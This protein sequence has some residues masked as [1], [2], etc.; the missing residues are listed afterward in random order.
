M[1]FALS[2]T[3]MERSHIQS[4]EIADLL[5][6]VRDGIIDQGMHTLENIGLLVYI[7]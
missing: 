4:C 1:V 6:E 7:L 5:G 2:R 3:G